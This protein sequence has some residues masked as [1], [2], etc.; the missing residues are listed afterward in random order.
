MVLHIV[1]FMTLLDCYG[2]YFQMY[3]YF[4]L[5]VRYEKLLDCL[6]FNIL[7]DQYIMYYK[8]FLSWKPVR[9]SREDR[10]FSYN[11]CHWTALKGHKMKY[12]Q[13]YLVD[14]LKLNWTFF[15]IWLKLS[16]WQPT[17]NSKELT[18]R[19]ETLSRSFIDLRIL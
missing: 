19:R 2:I 8:F 14:V 1:I 11:K 9:L 6:F 13:W 16:S 7:I 4:S 12:V 3:L 10:L 17:L 18:K 5:E 15:V